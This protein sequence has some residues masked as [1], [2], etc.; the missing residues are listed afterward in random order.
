MAFYPQTT[1]DLALW[2]EPIEIGYQ[3][4]GGGDGSA[5]AP[6][7]NHLG[8][9]DLLFMSS[10]MLLPR[11]RRPWGIATWLAEVFAVSR[12][13]LYS[14]PRRVL[15]RL[16]ARQPTALPDRQTKAEHQVEVKATRLQRTVLT[17]AFPGKI[18]LRPLQEL[19]TE[20]FDESR[21]IGWMSELLTEAGQKA[22]Q[23]LKQ[24]DFSAA[25]PV[26]VLRDE[27]FFQDRPVLFMVDPLSSTILSACVA[28]DRQADTWGIL[29]LMAQDQGVDIAGLIEDM[30]RM[31][32]KSLREAGLDDLEESVQKDLWHLQRDGGQL[33]RDLE[34][35]AFRATKQV[36]AL[37]AKL[38][39]AWNAELFLNQYI[40]AV[41][42]EAKR[43][44]QHD[45]FVTW[46]SHLCDALESVDLRSGAIRDYPTNAWLLN[47]VLDAMGKIDAERVQQWV[48]TLR[49]HQA[50]LLTWMAWLTPALASFQTQLAQ[51]L[52]H[53]VAQT[54][55]IQLVAQQWRLRQALVNGQR[56]WQL[57]A[58]HAIAMLQS[59]TVGLPALAALAQRLTDI[60]D[61]ACRTSSLVECINGLLKQFLHNRRSFASADAMQAYLNLFALWHNMRVYQRGKR[62]GQSPY[63]RA[64]IQ[65]HTDDW[66]ELLGYTAA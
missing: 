3:L 6:K 43:Y 53:P 49:R 17:A 18:A 45:E 30:A 9:A 35:A 20:A 63:Q 31:Y 55:F 41:M 38:R 44:A 24:I 11:D 64:G 61:A 8:L 4:L 62:Q 60:L 56:H 33:C 57:A 47:E 15:E 37:E 12:P 10:I 28:P 51:V 23:V 46:F 29:L 52:E 16:T 66:L 42:T 48:K 19:L 27:T 7:L 39:K 1:A 65:L 14:L 40:P 32:P 13:T 58:D 59:V 36:L 26:L 50:Q 22:G 34:R 54:Q 2:P 25:G 5:L 21:S